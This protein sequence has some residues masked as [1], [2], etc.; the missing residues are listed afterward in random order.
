MLFRSQID[1]VK[2]QIQQ[3]NSSLRG[4]E[5]NLQYTRIHAPM[6]GTVVSLGAKQGQTLNANQS[7]PV[8]LRIAD[9]STM[10]VDAQVSEADVPKLA[11]GMEVYFTTIGNQA[12]RWYGKLRQLNPTP[13]VVNNV[14]LYDALFEVPNADRALMTQMTAQVFFVTAQAKDAVLVPLA[15]LRPERKGREPGQGQGARRAAASGSAAPSVAAPAIDP[16]SQFANG[17][18]IVTVVHNGGTVQEREIRVGAMNRVSAQVLSGLQPGEQV[19]AGV[20]A[21]VPAGRSAAAASNASTP[22]FPPRL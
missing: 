18:A 2:A 13:Q 20:R 11:L 4:N 17:R 12:K 16:R 10:T 7:A 14:V 15:A 19:V 5:A 8:V 3:T 9:L 21:A 1:A 22:R 6:S